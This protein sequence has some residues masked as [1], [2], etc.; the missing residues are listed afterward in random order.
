[1]M[2]RRARQRTARRPVQRPSWA[3]LV[4]LDESVFAN[5]CAEH[6]TTAMLAHLRLAIDDEI[7]SP[8]RLRTDGVR[9][10][11]TAWKLHGANLGI[12]VEWIRSKV[13]HR[14]AQRL[15]FTG[16]NRDAMK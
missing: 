12:F 16:V 2:I 13:W 7:V 10:A 3:S 4:L 14:D 6:E 8:A 5:C 15:S 11:K 1:M 9:D